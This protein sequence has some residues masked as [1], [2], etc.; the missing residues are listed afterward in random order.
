MA[1]AEG[2]AARRAMPGA[3]MSETSSMPLLSRRCEPARRPPRATLAAAVAALVLG[4]CAVAPPAMGGDACRLGAG[5]AGA[6]QIQAF[7]LDVLNWSPGRFETDCTAGADQ[8]GLHPADRLRLAL[9]YSAPNNPRRSPEQ[10]RRL[11]AEMNGDAPADL[12]LGAQLVLRLTEDAL[13]RDQRLARAEDRLAAERDRADAEARRAGDAQRRAAQAEERARESERRLADT[14]ARLN[15]A[16]RRLEALRSVEDT[17]SR[18]AAQRRSAIGV[19]VPL[20]AEAASAP[21]RASERASDRAPSP[22]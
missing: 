6:A 17:I 19:A 2:P 21:A 20:P 7:W 3:D 14:G 4:G 16:T 18:R 11:L 9:A 5:G 15:D 13:A 1:G 22:R 10:T 8:A 12:R